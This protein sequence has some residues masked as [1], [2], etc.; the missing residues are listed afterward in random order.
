MLSLSNLMQLLLPNMS[1]RWKSRWGFLDIYLFVLVEKA[2]DW[3]LTK[4]YREIHWLSQGMPLWALGE[5]C[6]VSLLFSSINSLYLLLTYKRCNHVR[7][8]T[9][10]IYPGRPKKKKKKSREPFSLEIDG[11]HSWFISFELDTAKKQN[12]GSVCQLQ[13]HHLTT[14]RASSST[15][16]TRACAQIPPSWWRIWKGLGEFL[17]PQAPVLMCFTMWP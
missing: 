15:S 7:G 13:P 6:P 9:R 10:K 2:S 3:P 8:A 17:V 5:A 16:T 1:P 14:Q 11:S 4:D 12:G